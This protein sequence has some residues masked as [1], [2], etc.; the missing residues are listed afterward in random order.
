LQRYPNWPE[1]DELLYNLPTAVPED[2]RP[3]DEEE[4]EA[5]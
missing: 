2:A 4:Q 5:A 3:D 1:L